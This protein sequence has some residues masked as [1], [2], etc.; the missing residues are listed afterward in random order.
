VT[1]LSQALL[2][3]IRREISGGMGGVKKSYHGVL[4]LGKWVGWGSVGEDW[5]MPMSCGRT[6]LRGTLGGTKRA[7]FW[8]QLRAPVFSTES[9]ENPPEFPALTCSGLSHSGQ[10]LEDGVVRLVHRSKRGKWVAW[11]H[12]PPVVG[13][14]RG[15][16]CDLEWGCSLFSFLIPGLIGGSERRLPTL[17]LLGTTLGL[18]PVLGRVQKRSRGAHLS[19]P[20]ASGDSE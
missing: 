20:T 15:V 6:P 16:G 17:A 10:C 5:P 4:K 14:E 19:I 13:G 7:G 12:L 9:C 2:A 11:V 8:G 18:S 3:G 1:L